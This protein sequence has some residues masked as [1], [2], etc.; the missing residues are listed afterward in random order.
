MS[1]TFNVYVQP[2]TRETEIAGWHGELIKIRIQACASE[3]RA[4]QAVLSFIA[5]QLRIRMSRV[6][7]IKGKKSRTKVIEIADYTT[8]FSDKS[9]L[10]RYL[11][12]YFVKSRQ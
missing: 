6:R 11:Q 7:L 3:G 1:I 8:E 12:L 4:N 10:E 9:E 2:G 5:E